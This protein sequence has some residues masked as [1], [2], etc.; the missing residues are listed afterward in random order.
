MPAVG[1]SLAAVMAIITGVCINN[2]RK[3][4]RKEAYA[5]I[6]GSVHQPILDEIDV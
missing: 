4:K 3:L 5:N 2:C 1:F 6:E